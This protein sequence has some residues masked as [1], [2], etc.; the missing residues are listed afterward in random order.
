MQKLDLSENSISHLHPQI[1]A[2]QNQLSTLNLQGN[3]LEEIQRNVFDGLFI[4]ESL[5]LSRNMVSFFEE[6]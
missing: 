1:F 4:L 6:S 5:N 3:R 2:H